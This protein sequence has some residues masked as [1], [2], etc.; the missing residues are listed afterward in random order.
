MKHAEFNTPT[1]VNQSQTTKREFG[2]RGCRCQVFSIA[3]FRTV[4]QKLFKHLVKH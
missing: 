4:H 1:T 3:F 2:G